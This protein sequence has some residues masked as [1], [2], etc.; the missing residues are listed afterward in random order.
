M[1]EGEQEGSQKEIKQNTR[2]T[3]RM[4]IDVVLDTLHDGRA[5]KQGLENKLA[6]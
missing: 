4:P 2:G 5:H 3:E 1:D 6:V